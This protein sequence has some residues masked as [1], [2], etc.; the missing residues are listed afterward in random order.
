MRSLPF[1]AAAAILAAPLAAQQTGRITGK[2]LDSA[3]KPIPNA[4]VV[5]KRLDVTFVKEIKV[6]PK[7]GFVQVGLE[8]KEYEMA[9]SAEGYVGTRETV[10]IPLNDFLIKNI[11]LLTPDQQIA[12][13]GAAKTGG[14]KASAGDKAYT[15]AVGQYN[16]KNYAEAVP[17]FE[18]AVEYYSDAI[19]GA[20][21]AALTDDAG[22]FHAKAVELLA[23]S[24][25][26]VGLA[27]AG[28]RG[29][30]WPKAEPVLKAAF[31]KFP[32]DDKSQE[33]ARLT[34]QLVEIAKMRGDAA[35]EKK[36][37][38]VLEAI[39]GPKAGNSYHTAVAL[40]NA[41]KLPEA[42]PHLK[43]AIEI[44]PS[45]A[46]TYYLLAFCEL[47]G[48]DLKA[49]KACFQNSIELAPKG[50]YAAEVKEFLA[51]L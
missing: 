46:D 19:A 20:A 36:Y 40:Y 37:N 21:D 17:L 2:V 3:G 15:Q 33:R 24:R 50:K 12:Q 48:G 44:D 34:Y 18:S 26:E 29:D 9:V 13:S 51:D 14:L 42:K 38:D 25:F 7:G 16:D 39:E 41:N 6:D 11:T 49:A 32:A 28:R 23:D 31:D 22:Q 35:L 8:P 43:K 45:F 5:L 1:F 47:N 30:L 27:D 4:V 10:K